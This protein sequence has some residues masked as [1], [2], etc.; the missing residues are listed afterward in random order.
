M[1]PIGCG[2]RPSDDCGYISTL[3]WVR[4]RDDVCRVGLE[5]VFDY[6]R[7]GSHGKCGGEHINSAFEMLRVLASS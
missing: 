2:D 5:D 3:K 4:P 6:A 7:L 1:Q